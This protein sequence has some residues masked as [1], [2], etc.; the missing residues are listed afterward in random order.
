MVSMIEYDQGANAETTAHHALLSLFQRIV[1]VTNPLAAVSVDPGQILALNG[2]TVES[3]VT[4]PPVLGNNNRAECISCAVVDADGS[5][6]GH[7]ISVSGDVPVSGSAGGVVLE[8]SSVTQ[9]PGAMFFLST[10]LG[11]WIVI[12]CCASAPS[13]PP[14]L[15]NAPSVTVNA[16]A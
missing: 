12:S 2:L 3:N 6:F 8:A 7:G 11:E 10:Q 1:G 4:L 13:P 15:T 9:R 5:S 14:P 16:K